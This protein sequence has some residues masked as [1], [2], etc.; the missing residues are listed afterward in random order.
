MSKYGKKRISSMDM[1]LKNG[2]KILLVRGYK[3]INMVYNLLLVG[4]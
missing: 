2:D 3:E 1:I 4:R